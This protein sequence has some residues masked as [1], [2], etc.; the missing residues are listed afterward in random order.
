MTRRKRA[1]VLTLIALPGLWIVLRLVTGDALAMDFYHLS[2]EM[3]V[4]LMIAAL[5]PGPLVAWFGAGPLL[6]GWLAVRRNLGVG[7]AC[8]A[9]LHLSLYI[10]EMRQVAAMLDE[11][12]LPAIW[13]GWIALA[14]LCIPAAISFDR[15]ARTLGRRWKALQRLVYPAFLIAI[16][17]WLLL[18]WHW[19]PAALHLAPVLAAWVLRARAQAGHHQRRMT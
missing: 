11:L 18:D 7:A 12:T 14:L 15:A 4:R 19:V 5:L 10:I 2:G 9:L 3:A 6:R 16:A 8:Y 13:T 1:L 17:H